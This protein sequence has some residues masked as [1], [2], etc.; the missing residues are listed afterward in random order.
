MAFPQSF[1]QAADVV[2]A[3]AVAGHKGYD[4]R[5]AQEIVKRCFVLIVHCQLSRC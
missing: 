3:H 4:D 5:F 2:G 1:H